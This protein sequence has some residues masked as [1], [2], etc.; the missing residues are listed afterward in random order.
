[1]QHNAL[2]YLKLLALDGDKYFSAGLKK[3]CNVSLIHLGCCCRMR[4]LT[5]PELPQ[6]PPG[7]GKPSEAVTSACGRTLH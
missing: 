5:F 1:M 3:G 2:G 4:V 6:T 7:G